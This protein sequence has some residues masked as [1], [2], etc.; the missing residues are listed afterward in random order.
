MPYKIFI[1]YTQLDLAIAEDVKR[2]V[3]NAF[4]GE[5]SLYLA[6]HEI[7]GGDAWKE[8][9]NTQL[10]NCDAIISIVTPRSIAK[11]W[12]IIEWSAFWLQNKKFYT[13]LTDEV[14][15]ADLLDPMTDRQTTVMTRINDVKALFKAIAVDAG[16]KTVPFEFA[17]TFAED[18]EI[19]DRKIFSNLANSQYEKYKRDLSLIPEDD[20]RKYEIAS[21]FY[22]VKDFEYFARVAELIKQNPIKARLATYLIN[23]GDITNAKKLTIN[24]HSADDLRNV[25]KRLIEL[26]YH[27]DKI[28]RNILEDLSK[29]NQAELRNIMF[30]LI[31][32]G[33]T[34]SDLFQFIT[35]LF[36]NMVELRKVAISLSENGQ[37]N[38]DAFSQISK[39]IANHNQIE[40][41]KLGEELIKSNQ[42]HLS[43]FVEMIIQLSTKNLAEAEKLF[44]ILVNTDLSTAK[45]YISAGKLSDKTIERFKK[46]IP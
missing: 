26:G 40:L 38:S 39:K 9:L 3:N 23:S 16:V 22:Q 25:A 13:L 29:R 2:I 19:S 41:R 20:D 36:I 7:L 6:A 42:Y 37:T 33:M 34:D 5:V 44:A 17:E 1:S 11:P 12:I 32:L 31:E 24:I 30:G 10:K 14:K 21:H 8:Q 35:S 18:I 4:Q 15:V 28:L 43:A 27:D 45:E 46:L